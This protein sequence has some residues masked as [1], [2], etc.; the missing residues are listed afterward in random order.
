MPLAP[1]RCAI[2]L[3]FIHNNHTPLVTVASMS[4]AANIEYPPAAHTTY[5]HDES[6]ETPVVTSVQPRA[7]ATM[8]V[9]PNN[10]RTR[11]GKAERLRGG[12]V[13]C[14]VCTESMLFVC[15]YLV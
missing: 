4:T 3:N 11:T 10:D 12:C 14:P 6:A 2:H 1:Q 8:T 5:H 9:G 15:A 13:P 7:G